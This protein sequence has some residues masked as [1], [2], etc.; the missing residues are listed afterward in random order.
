MYQSRKGYDRFNPIDHIANWSTPALIISN[1][2]DYRVPITEGLAAF[3]ILQAK[4]VDSRFLSFPDEGHT[5]VKPD[6]RLHWWH[7][8]IDWCTQYTAQRPST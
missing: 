7:V 2:K 6:K 1:E 3:Q 5:T 4:G 8:V